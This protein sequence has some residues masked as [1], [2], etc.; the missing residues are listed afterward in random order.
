[1]DGVLEAKGFGGPP[2]VA[3]EFGVAETPPTHPLVTPDGRALQMVKSQIDAF[4]EEGKWDD[5]KKITNPYE[6]VFLSWNRRSRIRIGSR[7]CPRSARSRCT[8]S[9]L[10][11]QCKIVCKYPRQ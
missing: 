6:Y 1:M 3:L 4:Y 7:D 10:I 8:H 9:C 2:T 11:P 5:Y